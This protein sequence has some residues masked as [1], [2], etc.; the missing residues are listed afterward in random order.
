MLVYKKTEI[1]FFPDLNFFFQIWNLNGVIE[2]IKQSK[3]RP[4]QKKNQQQQQLLYVL[5]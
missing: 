3:P 4:L 5:P 1:S 2:F